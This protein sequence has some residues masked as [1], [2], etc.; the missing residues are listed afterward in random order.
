MYLNAYAPVV[1]FYEK[2]GYKILEGGQAHGADSKYKDAQCIL[3]K[4]SLQVEN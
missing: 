2:L 4:K 1:R 3:M